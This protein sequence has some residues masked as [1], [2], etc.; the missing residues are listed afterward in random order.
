MFNKCKCSRGVSKPWN[1]DKYSNELTPILGLNHFD[2]E[3]VS[4]PTWAAHER[5]SKAP[6]MPCYCLSD[7]QRQ[8]LGCN[9]VHVS[10]H[11]YVALIL[12]G[13]DRG[14]LHPH[15]LVLTALAPL[16]PPLARSAASE[17]SNSAQ[18]PVGGCVKRAAAGGQRHISGR[19]AG[20]VGYSN[21]LG[22]LHQHGDEGRHD[23]PEKS[24]GTMAAGIRGEGYRCIREACDGECCVDYKSCSSS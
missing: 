3:S 7:L 21:Y 15:C 13:N 17:H 20:G 24:S 10:S 1:G 14:R 9:A 4:S 18:I 19:G 16:L 6:G 2:D 22:R 5:P 23:L 12:I 11:R 8:Q